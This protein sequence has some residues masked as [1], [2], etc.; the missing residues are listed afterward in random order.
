M[1]LLVLMFSLLWAANAQASLIKISADQGSYTSGDI[2]TVE[3]SVE[4]IN[5]AVDFLELDLSF[6]LVELAFVEDSWFDSDALLDY[7]AFGDAFLGLFDDKLIVQ[8]SF[9]DG[10]VDVASSSFVLGQF[11]FLAQEDIDNVNLS[12]DSIFATDANF[13]EIA[14]EELQVSVPAPNLGLL[15]LFGF[16]LLAFKRYL[17]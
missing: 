11:E 13:I 10:I 15:L 3:L 14:Q 9:L 5:S 17:K 1:K 12:L 8:A 16:I 7:G 2:V 4:N 6:D